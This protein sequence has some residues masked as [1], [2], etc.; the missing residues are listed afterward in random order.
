MHLE[1]S[2][3][4]HPYTFIA[5]YIDSCYGVG[6]KL[7]F[8]V[9]V[10]LTQAQSVI[11]EDGNVEDCNGGY[12]VCANIMGNTVHHLPLDVIFG[13]TSPALIPRSQIAEMMGRILIKFHMSLSV[14][15]ISTTHKILLISYTS[16]TEMP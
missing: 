4:S 5:P 13:A 7:I 8:A 9:E 15:S 11:E 10:D 12:C 3:I 6:G 2:K 1:Y 16:P 14:C